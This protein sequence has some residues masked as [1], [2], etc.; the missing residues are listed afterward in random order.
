MAL[1][2]LLHYAFSTYTC[3]FHHRLIPV[4][5][6]AAEEKP[7]RASPARAPR[8]YDDAQITNP[9]FINDL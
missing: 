3:I 4:I 1:P 8:R 7:I 9:V 2:P 6:M 5:R